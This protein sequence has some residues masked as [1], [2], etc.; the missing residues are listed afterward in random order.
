MNFPDFDTVTGVSGRA[1]LLA[2]IAAAA[3]LRW[4]RELTVVG[5]FTALLL[6]TAA[7][8][9]ITPALMSFFKLAPV[10]ENGIAFLI[11]L[12]ALQAVPVLYAL[13]DRVRGAKLPGL[14]DVPKE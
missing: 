12:G 9:A 8:I 7:A 13:L 6:G 3:S 4:A 1:T 10:Y 5:A 2:F 11:G 14:P